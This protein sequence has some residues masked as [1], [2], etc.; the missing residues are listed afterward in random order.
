MATRRSFGSPQYGTAPI[1]TGPQGGAPLPRP[2]GEIPVRL[3][4]NTATPPP[5]NGAAAAG[6]PPAGHE[7]QQPN[8]LD[9]SGDPNQ[10]TVELLQMLGLL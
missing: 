7:P 3:P 4:I 9:L 1:Q 6:A 5:A 2:D 10:Q 8:P